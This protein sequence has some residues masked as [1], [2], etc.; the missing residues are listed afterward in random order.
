MWQS[1]IES[2]TDICFCFSWWSCV[3]KECVL[4]SDDASGQ[5]WPIAVSPALFLLSSSLLIFWPQFQRQ[6][7]EIVLL[8]LAHQQQYCRAGSIHRTTRQHQ[9]RLSGSSLWCWG[10]HTLTQLSNLTSLG[11]YPTQMISTRTNLEHVCD[12]YHSGHSIYRDTA[13]CWR[14]FSQEASS[15][16]PAGVE[17]QAF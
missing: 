8:R 4:S 6:Y 16:P 10:K 2:V 11:L 13:L 15:L 12:H 9:W 3:L 17:T 14:Y 1:V 5:I 7:G